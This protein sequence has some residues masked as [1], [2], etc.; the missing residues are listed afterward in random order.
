MPP[1]FHYAITHCFHFLML[2]LRRWPHYAVSIFS[3][4]IATP[5]CRHIADAIFDYAAAAIDAAIDITPPLLCQIRC[6]PLRHC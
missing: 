2:P 1:P 5:C 4:D 3:F 6:T